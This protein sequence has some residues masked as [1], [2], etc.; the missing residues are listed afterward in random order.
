MSQLQSFL[1][2]LGNSEY[3]KVSDNGNWVI[4]LTDPNGNLASFTFDKNGQYL[5][6]KISI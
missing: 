6:F 3:S 5:E 2:M 4:K 1:F